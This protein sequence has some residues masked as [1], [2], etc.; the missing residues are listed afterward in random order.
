MTEGWTSD[1]EKLFAKCLIDADYRTQLLSALAND[2]D[3]TVINLLNSIGA[4]GPE[5]L[6]SVR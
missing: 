5:T 2:E 4:A 6:R 3:T 1:W